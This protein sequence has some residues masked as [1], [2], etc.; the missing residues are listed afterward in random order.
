MDLRRLPRSARSSRSASAATG[1]QGHSLAQWATSTSARRL[2]EVV[3]GPVMAQVGR[4]VDVGHGGRVGEGLA[5]RPR[6]PRPCARGRRGRRHAHAVMGRRQRGRDG[7]GER[8]EGNG[9]GERADPSG[10]DAGV[11]G[12]RDEGRRSRQAEGVG[13]GVG[14]AR[15]GIVGVRVGAEQRDAVRDE[16]VDDTA[17]WSTAA[18]E[19]TPRRRRGWCVTI[20]SACGGRASSTTSA[21]G[22]TANSTRLTRRPG[23]RRRA[24][25]HPSRRRA[26]TGSGVRAARR[27]HGRSRRWTRRSGYPVA[28]A[29]FG[30]R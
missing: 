3:L 19:W 27:R 10:P 23:R 6:T 2:D 25:P 9:L 15:V 26:P 12:H 20:M 13:E 29:S 22:S 16:R 4:D 14:D 7:L 28:R 1:S 30:D 8:G 11:A 17:L 21:T 24:Q 18:T 5:A